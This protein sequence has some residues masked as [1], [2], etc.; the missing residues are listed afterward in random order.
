M[1]NTAIADIEILTPKGGFFIIL[2]IA[3]ECPEIPL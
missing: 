1:C 2:V 3:K